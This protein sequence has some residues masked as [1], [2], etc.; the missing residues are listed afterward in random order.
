VWNVAEEEWKKTEEASWEHPLGNGGSVESLEHH[1]VVQVCWYDAGAFCDWLNQNHNHEL[2]NGYHFRLPSEAEWEKAVRGP[3]G[4][5]WP[6]GNSFDPELCNSRESGRIHTVEIGSFSPQGD[7]EYGLADT[8]GNVWEW[9]I[10]LW[11]ED[12]DTPS[13]VYP[14]SSQDGREDQ[15]AGESVYRIIRGGSYKD[16]LKGVRSACRDLDPPNYS[17]SNL[18]FRVFVVPMD[19]NEHASSRTLDN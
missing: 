4:F 15:S 16:D 6:W 7:S 5:V 13:F 2:P 19:A 3:K 12:R 1:P 11:G 9:T 14:Y 17:L 18:G 10:T 8:S